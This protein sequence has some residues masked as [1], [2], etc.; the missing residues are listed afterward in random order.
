MFLTSAYVFIFIYMIS[1]L[2]PYN[3]DAKYKEDTI[4]N[5][6]SAFSAVNFSVNDVIDLIWNDKKLKY[7][8]HPVYIES[9]E[10]ISS[11]RIIDNLKK[12]KSED[13]RAYL[14]LKATIQSREDSHFWNILSVSI[15]LGSIFITLYSNH[16]FYDLINSFTSLSSSINKFKAVFEITIGMVFIMVIAVLVKYAGIE[17][18]KIFYKELLMFFDEA[19]K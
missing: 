10:E 2:L 3:Y 12:L 7:F 14:K 8:L 15:G 18:N 16:F 19:E 5:F 13:L 4:G 17:A 6:F 11:R 9:N 1:I